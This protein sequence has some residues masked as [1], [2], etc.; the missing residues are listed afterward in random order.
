MR[1]TK[2]HTAYQYTQSLWV[3][4]FFIYHAGQKT[5]LKNIFKIS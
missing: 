1:A 4:G 5:F 2:R 3:A